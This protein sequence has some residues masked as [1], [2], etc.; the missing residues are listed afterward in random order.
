[1]KKWRA[2]SPCPRQRGFTFNPFML[3]M[4]KR[5]CVLAGSSTLGM[6][7]TLR[8]SLSPV[9]RGVKLDK[10]ADVPLLDPAEYLVQQLNGSKRGDIR[11]IEP[12]TH[13]DNVE[14]ANWQRLED[15][16]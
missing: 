16:L 1:M 2:L 5:R 3:I 12:W 14:G 9:N 4:V 15:G 8:V 10:L 7:L 6:L 11:R 13:L